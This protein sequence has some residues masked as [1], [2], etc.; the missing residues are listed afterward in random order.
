MILNKKRVW[1]VLLKPIDYHYKSY[2]ETIATKIIQEESR[3]SI[4]INQLYCIAELLYC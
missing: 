4:V 3:P 1:W 2:A